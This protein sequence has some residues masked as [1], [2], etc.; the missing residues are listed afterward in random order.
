MFYHLFSFNG[1]I[2][3]LEYGLTFLA[4]YLYELPMELIS[5]DELSAGFALVWLLLLIPALWI[6]Y[7]QGAKRCHDMNNSGWYQLIPFYALWMIFKKGDTGSNNYGDEARDQSTGE[8]NSVGYFLQKK[9]IKARVQNKGNV[10]SQLKDIGS[11][12]IFPKKTIAS[13]SWAKDRTLLIL[14]AIGLLPTL[15]WVVPLWDW[16]V[17]YFISLYFAVIWGLFFYYLFK[18]NQVSLKA[19]LTV[20]FLEQAFIFL[21]WNVLG[22]PNLNPFYAFTKSVFPVS[23]LG[24]V[25]GVG[26]TE[27]LAKLIPL[28]IIASMSKKP[29]IPQTLVFYGLMSGIAFGVFEGVEYQLNTNVNLEYTQSFFYNISRLTSLPFM[30][31]VWCGI[32]GYFISFAKLYPKYRIS[33]YALALL[34]PAILHGIYDSLVGVNIIFVVLAIAVAFVGVIMLMTYLKQGVNYQSKL[35]N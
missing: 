21:A 31:A 1:R 2:R 13:R 17:H 22:I 27:E 14:A 34:V 4:L 30:H 19:T 12:L 10:F 9:K 16:G 29:L 15:L 20:F 26:I 18:T 24:F 5:E 25:F 35:R 8:V 32:A 23:I 7:A 28:L 11:E 6:F 33:L 3:R